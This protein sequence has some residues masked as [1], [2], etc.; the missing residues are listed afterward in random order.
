MSHKAKDRPQN[1]TVADGVLLFVLQQ[2]ELIC[3]QSK[4]VSRQL[5]C[6]WLEETVCDSRFVFLLEADCHEGFFRLLKNYYLNG[7]IFMNIN[8]GGKIHTTNFAIQIPL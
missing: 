4:V 2:G 8:I 1:K 7:A 3:G 5:P 6:H